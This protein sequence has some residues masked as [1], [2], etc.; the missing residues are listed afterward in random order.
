MWY[1]HTDRIQQLVLKDFS[2][3]QTKTPDWIGLDPSDHELIKHQVTSA[4]SN[5]NQV[6]STGADRNQRAQFK[7]SLYEMIYILVNDP[8]EENISLALV[9]IQDDYKTWERSIDKFLNSQL[10]AMT[11]TF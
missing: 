11:Y 5:I 1:V 6:V 8:T 9:H 3:Y 7:E 2:E 10:Y 4:L